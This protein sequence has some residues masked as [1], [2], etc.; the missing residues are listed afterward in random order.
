MHLIIQRELDKAIKI[1]NQ[2]QLKY[3]IEDSDGII[4]GE[5]KLV[6]EKKPEKKIPKYP[7]NSLRDWVA[8]HIQLLSRGKVGLIPYAEFDRDYVQSA[9][10]SQA[11]KKWGAYNYT[12]HMTDQ[13]IEIYVYPE[14]ESNEQQIII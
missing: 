5:L 7:R 9:S 10:C 13:G 12:T 8:P 6:P 1:L 4:H 2:I 14:G 11:N 3:A